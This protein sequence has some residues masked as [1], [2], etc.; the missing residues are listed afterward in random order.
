MNKIPPINRPPGYTV[1]LTGESAYLWALFLRN[2]ADFADDHVAY[3]KWQT[4]VEILLPKPGKAMPSIVH[5][6]VLED[7][8]AKYESKDYINPSNCAQE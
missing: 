2:E 1:G 6:S 8:I 3:D 5:F 4:L 7:E